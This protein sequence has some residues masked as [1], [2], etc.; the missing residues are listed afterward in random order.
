M[1][2]SSK[3]VNQEHLQVLTVHLPKNTKSL[4]G[5]LDSTL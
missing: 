4:A 3:T 1:K 5:Q 2:C